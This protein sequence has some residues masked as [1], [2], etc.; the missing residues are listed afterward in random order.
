MKNVVAFV[1]LAPKIYVCKCKIPL[2]HLEITIY[3]KMQKRLNLTFPQCLL[4]CSRWVNSDCSTTYSNLLNRRF[5]NLLEGT[6]TENILLELQETH[7]FS[8]LLSPLERIQT[9]AI[10][11]LQFKQ[12][13]CFAWEQITSLTSLNKITA[14][15]LHSNHDYNNCSYLNSYKSTVN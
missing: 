10:D 12:S 11:W 4:L 3:G 8:Q 9:Q 2:T 15:S 14:T 1:I 6:T 5:H 13:T 7:S